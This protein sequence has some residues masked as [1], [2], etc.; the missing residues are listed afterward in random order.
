MDRMNEPIYGTGNPNISGEH[1]RNYMN[2]MSERRE[3]ERIENI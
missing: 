3:W 2:E 1:E